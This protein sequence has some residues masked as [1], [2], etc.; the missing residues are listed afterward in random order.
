MGEIGKTEI[1]E[2]YSG[3]NTTFYSFIFSCI[4]LD[5]FWSSDWTL[6]PCY[7]LKTREV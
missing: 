4:L 5:A 2:R 1:G 3:I 6:R 7:R